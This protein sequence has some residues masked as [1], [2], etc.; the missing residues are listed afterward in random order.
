MVLI[1]GGS[2]IMGSSDEDVLAANDNPTRT[3]SLRSFGWMKKITN[4]D[5]VNL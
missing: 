1:P 2:Y 5:I 4:G 3:V